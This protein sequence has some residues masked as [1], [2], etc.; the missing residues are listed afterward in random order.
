[1]TWAC[2]PTLDRIGYGLPDYFWKVSKNSN[3][4]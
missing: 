4:I 2:V 1:L 3:T